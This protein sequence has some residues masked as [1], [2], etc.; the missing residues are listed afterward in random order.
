MKNVTLADIANKTG[1]SVNT[2][3]HALHDK[4]DISAKTKEQIQAVAKEM[5]YIRNSSA[6]SLDLERRKVS[7]SS[8]AIFPTPI[9]RS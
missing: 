7:P 3:S 1:F 6:S 5:G 4:K 8:L 2:V 9:F